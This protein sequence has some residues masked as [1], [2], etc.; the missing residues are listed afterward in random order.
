[1]E[2]QEDVALHSQV[3]PRLVLGV[4]RILNEGEDLEAS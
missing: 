3:E 2:Q 1:M 4:T